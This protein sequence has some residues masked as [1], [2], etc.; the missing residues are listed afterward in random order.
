M[1]LDFTICQCFL[2]EPHPN[3]HCQDLQSQ[4]RKGGSETIY[5]VNQIQSSNYK[6]QVK[7]KKRET[8]QILKMGA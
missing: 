8:I 4:K 1:F 2:S 6:T 7:N 3:E 5:A